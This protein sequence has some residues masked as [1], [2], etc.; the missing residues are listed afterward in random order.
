VKPG[1]TAWVSDR[2]AWHLIRDHVI[3]RRVGRGSWYFGDGATLTLLLG[4]LVGTGAV[5]TLTY[6]PT[7]DAAYESVEHITNQVTLGWFVRALHYWAA[8]MMVVMLFFHLFRQI[9][10]GGYKSP[11]EGTWLIGVM[12]FFAVITMSF[13]G[14]LLRWDERAI[15]GIRVALHM[16]HQVPLIGDGL[17]VFVQGGPEMGPLTLTRLFSLHVILLPLVIFG[18]VGFHLYLVIVHGTTTPGERGR[19][20]HSAEEQRA[21]YEE[22]K[23]SA[24]RGESFYPTTM[25]K[26]GTMGL[27]VFLFVV[28]LAILYGPAPLYPEG[29]LTD[30]SFPAEEWWLGWYSSLIALLPPAVAPIFVVAFP[31]VLFLCLVLLPFVDRSP[32]REIRKRP[33]A[34]LTV[35]ALVIALLVLTDMRRRSPW[36][37]WPDPEPP[38]VPRGFT[39][40]EEVEEGRQLFA[41][42][43]C[44]SCHPVAGVGRQVAID[45]ADLKGR[46]TRA[47]IRDFILEPPEDVA[48]PSYAGRMTEEELERVIDYVHVAQTFPRRP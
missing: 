16:F 36:T 15:Y 17:V 34:A 13:T 3:I 6:A 18:L 22:D 32:Y 47:R 24:E 39:L 35:V 8:G 23:H 11:R 7:P 21:I 38:P 42:F 1:W 26:S 4:V 29:N 28:G 43:G 48:M 31:I 40:T 45:L 25:A 20:V 37:G 9:L 10:L 41:Q 33:F 46:L 19:P 2:F 5:M 30:T 44:N 12:L 27:V 14:Y